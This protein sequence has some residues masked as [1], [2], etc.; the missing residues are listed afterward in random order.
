MLLFV[1]LNKSDKDFSPSTQYDDY[2]INKDFFH[3]QSRN[4]DRHNS[5]WGKIYTQQSEKQ[6]KIVLFVREDKKDGFGNTTPFHCFGLVDYVSSQ[7][8]APM[9]ITW[10]LHEPV[11]ARFLKVV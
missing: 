3:W 4:S 2:V 6:H 5:K 11:M 10:R 9:N 8:D 1:T 7:G